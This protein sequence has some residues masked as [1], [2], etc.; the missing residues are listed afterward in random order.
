MGFHEAHRGDHLNEE[1]DE[2]KIC[3]SIVGAVGQL[4]EE[5]DGEGGADEAKLE[6]DEWSYSEYGGEHGQMV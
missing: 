3:E 2:S 4:S 6:H 1:C 5:P